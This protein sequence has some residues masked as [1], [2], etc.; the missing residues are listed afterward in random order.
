MTWI[1]RLWPWH[2]HRYSI[3]GPVEPRPGFARQ[4]DFR[5]RCGKTITGEQLFAPH[6]MMGRYWR[7]RRGASGVGLRG[8]SQQRN[9]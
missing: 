7:S 9:P 2:E 5:C 6:T 4:A 8:I 3:V 1:L